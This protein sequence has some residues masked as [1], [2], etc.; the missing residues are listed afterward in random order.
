MKKKIVTTILFAALLLIPANGDENTYKVIKVVDGDT[1]YVDFNK[2]GVSER[3]EKVR[4]NGIDTFETKQ[5]SSIE[6]QEKRYKLSRQEVLAL[7]YYGK[8]FAKKKLLNKKVVAKYTANTKTDKN[9]RQLMS[10]YYDCKEGVCKS[11]EEEVLKEG[12][13]VVYNNSNIAEELRPYENINKIKAR[14]KKTRRL[15]LVI[16]NRKTNKYHKIDCPN[17]QNLS[18]SEIIKQ[19]LLY[20]KKAGC[21]FNEYINPKADYKSAKIEIYFLDPLRQYGNNKRTEALK[22]LISLIKSSESRIYFAVYG[23]SNNIVMNELV[24][25]YKSGLDIKWVTDANKFGNNNYSRT[26]YL[27]E[28]IPNFRTDKTEEKLEFNTRQEVEFLIKNQKIKAQFEDSEIKYF[29]DQLMHNKFFIFDNDVVTTG[30]V[31]ISNTG[32]NGKYINANDFIVINSEKVNDIY[33]TEFN[34]MYKGLFHREKAKVR[35]KKGLHL[36][37]GT[38]LSIY[39]APQDN[40]FL[41]DIVEIINTTDSYIYVPMFFLTDKRIAQALIN[42]HERNVDVKVILDAASAMSKYSKHQILRIAGIPVKVEN[43]AGKMHMKCLITDKYVVTGSLNWTNRAQYFN[44]E[45]SL[46]IQSEKIAN[47][48]RKQFLRLYDSIP[49]KWL[50]NDPKP[51]G[52]DSP[53][54]CCDG[55]DNDHDGYT[56]MDDFDCNSKAKQGKLYN[57]YYQNL[58]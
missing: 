52:I 13:G 26:K 56:D 54:S 39:F 24:A 35:N 22:R 43:W 31:N 49:D 51:E 55:I 17:A 15:K 12:L 47:A 33:F 6:W 11:Y 37:D 53:Y 10:I 21:C 50:L 20:G 36:K 9:G 42:A 14:V 3:D 18:D 19:P 2:N 5:N 32:I 58:E 40:D 16:Y 41:E 1:I 7:G 48:Y 57:K 29:T 27:Q 23:I 25:R 38:I 34:Q 45:N 44:D 8:E 30:S 4:I 28:E 46:I